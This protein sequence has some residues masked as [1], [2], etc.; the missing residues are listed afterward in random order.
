MSQKK[1]AGLMYIRA[2]DGSIKQDKLDAKGTELARGDA[3]PLAREMQRAA[4]NA[5]MYERDVELAKSRVIE[6]MTKVANDEHPIEM[7]T[8]T[9]GLG[10][11]YAGEGPVH[12]KV[13]DLMR[14]RDPGSEPSIGDPV[15]FVYVEREDPKAKARDK[16][17]DVGYA[18]KHN[19]RVDRSHYVTNLLPNGITRAMGVIWDASELFRQCNETILRQRAKNDFEQS[20]KRKGTLFQMGFASAG[21]SADQDAEKAAPRADVAESLNHAGAAHATKKKRA[22]GSILSFLKSPK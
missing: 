17:E 10:K 15:P 5:L 20:K 7:Y 3:C 18:K 12:Q 13:V 14:A 21:Q 19:L 16:A 9:K 22:N 2:K 8:I 1:Y 6:F 11:D 4:L